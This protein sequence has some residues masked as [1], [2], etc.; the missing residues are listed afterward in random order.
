[1]AEN[2]QK[3]EKPL[4]NRWLVVIAAVV[5]ELA[6]GAIYAWGIYGSSMVALGWTDTQIQ[7]P[8]SISLAS[9]AVTTVFA[10]KLKEKIGPRILIIISAA[11]LGGGYLLAGILPLSP[12]MLVITIGIV[13]G[14]GIGFSYAL[15]ISTGVAWFPDKKGL[16]TGLGMAGFGAGA[17]IWYYLFDGIF[18]DMTNGLQIGFIVFG[19]CYAVF[20]M[21]SYFFLYEPPK[22]YTVPGY[23]PPVA[24]TADGE[25][26]EEFNME[27]KDMLK[28]PQFWMIFVSYMFGVGA[29]LMVIGIAKKW[30]ATV[31]TDQGLDPTLVNTV[32]QLAAALIY[33]LFN[34]LGRIIWGILAEKLSWKKALLIMNS[35]QTVFFILIMFLVKSPVGLIIG[36]AVMAFNYGGNFSLFPQATREAFGSKYISQNYGW[37]FLS[38]GV[39]GILIPMLGAVF[40]DA[41][42]QNWAFIVSAIG[43]AITVVLM[44]IYKK[45]QKN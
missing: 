35:V 28:T 22:D 17:L 21:F 3:T 7:I 6:L 18:K 9:F 43:L 36:M 11:C 23:T 8:Y 2:L 16:V 25:A 19:I 37:V 10:G 27:S 30:P 32:T 39:G 4:Q 13:G 33:P 15:P 20:V 14:A 12:V 45:P 44:V 34:G 1:M 40:S 41:G 38:Y 26:I 24:K 42:L 5:L 29:G 31:L